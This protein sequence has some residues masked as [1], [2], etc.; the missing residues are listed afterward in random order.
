MPSS[1]YTPEGAFEAMLAILALTLVAAIVY[2]V[3]FTGATIPPS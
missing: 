2:L 1:V 3:V